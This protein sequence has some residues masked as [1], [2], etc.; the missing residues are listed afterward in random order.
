MLYSWP[1]FTVPLAPETD[2]LLH[3]VAHDSVERMCNCVVSS[4]ITDWILKSAPFGFE[5]VFE[6]GPR[7]RFQKSAY[8]QRENVFSVLQLTLVFYWWLCKNN[9]V[10]FFSR[11]TTGMLK[12]RPTVPWIQVG[13]RSRKMSIFWELT[14][15]PSTGQWELYNSKH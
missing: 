14:Y 1:C 4:F 10:L 15:K 12:A 2:L 9:E 8:Y 3:I 13:F 6:V 7:G 5:A 11:I